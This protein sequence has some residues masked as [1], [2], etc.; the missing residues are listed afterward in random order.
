MKQIAGC[1]ATYC[2]RIHATDDG[3]GDLIVV[4]RA[5]TELEVRQVGPIDE[6]EIAVRI[7]ASLLIEVAP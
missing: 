2:P 3:T 4:G 1:S 7:P 6:D 5:L